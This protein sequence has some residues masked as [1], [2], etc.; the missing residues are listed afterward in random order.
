MA[1]RTTRIQRED[2]GIVEAAR[3]IGVNHNL[4]ASDFTKFY[5]VLDSPTQIAD[6]KF[7]HQVNFGAFSY[8]TGGFIFDTDVK[9]Y[10]SLSN[11]LHIGQQGHPLDWLSSHPF[12]YQRPPFVLGPSFLDK[13]LFDDDQKLVKSSLGK[14]LSSQV[15]RTVIGNDVW[16]AHGVYVKG[17]VTIGDGAVVGARSVVTKDIPPYAVVY[18][19]PAK[20]ARYRFSE[21]VIASLLEL[22]W[23]DFAP[24]QLRHI[25]FDNVLEA[26][27]QISILRERGEPE[28][29]SQALVVTR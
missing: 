14:S 8:V 7:R 25:N 29:V 12:Q 15:D 28:Y 9:R 1:E 26:V 19:T 27:R 10:C 24:W 20:I 21:D 23:W 17:G 2:A 13:K 11:G 3:N 16:L 5:G 6:T 4:S 22:R 18:G